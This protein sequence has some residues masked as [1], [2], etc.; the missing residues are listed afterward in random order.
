MAK[1]SKSKSWQSKIAHRGLSTY[2]QLINENK[3][4]RSAS[5]RSERPTRLQV[6]GRR[7]AEPQAEAIGDQRCELNSA[8]L[9]HTSQKQPTLKIK[10]TIAKIFCSLNE[11]S[12]DTK[13]MRR[14]IAEIA[15]P[16]PLMHCNEASTRSLMA[17]ELTNLVKT[18]GDASEIRVKLN[19]S[20]E[21]ASTSQVSAMAARG[22]AGKMP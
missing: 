1:S 7:V 22:A 18:R 13:T 9:R 15:T 11:N 14:L 4:L 2:Q 8:W 3:K 21:A 16:A 10:S 20:D 6:A 5:R 17:V 19:M 12:A